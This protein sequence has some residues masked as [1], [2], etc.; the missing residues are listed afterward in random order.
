MMPTSKLNNFLFSFDVYYIVFDLWIANWIMFYLLLLLRFRSHSSSTS[1]EQ[2]AIASAHVYAW[3]CVESSSRS[4]R[5]IQKTILHT[6]HRQNLIPKNKLPLIHLHFLLLI[7][8][9]VCCWC[10]WLNRQIVV[11]RV[12]ILYYPQISS[13]SHSHFIAYSL[14]PTF[15]HPKCEIPSIGL[16]LCWRNEYGMSQFVWSY[17][18]ADVSH[19][20]LPKEKKIFIADR[21]RTDTVVFSLV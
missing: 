14:S 11:Q 18:T 15:L 13:L 9:A 8:V 20:E 2:L 1:N 6:H 19:I 17:T 21:T 10:C 4:E 3:K 12:C 7:F 16:P 5:K